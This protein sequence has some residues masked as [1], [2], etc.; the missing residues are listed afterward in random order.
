MSALSNYLESKIANW[1]DGT[2]AG[3]APTIIYVELRNGNPTDT[4]TGATATTGVNRAAVTLA[5]A[6][7]GATSNSAIIEFGTASASGT[8]DYFG[9]WDASTAGNLLVYGA[10]T[11]SKSIS[12]GD[13]VTI[14]ASALTVT[15]TGEFSTYTKNLWLNWM[16][17]TAISTLTAIYQGLYN[18]DPQSAGTEVTTTIRV[19]GRVV[20]PLGTATDGIISSNADVD[21]GTAAGGATVS[22]LSVHDAASGGNL[23]AADAITSRTV[24]TGDPV[25]IPSGDNTFTIA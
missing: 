20:I 11:A 16:R 2:A 25:L 17:G 18:G 13:A 6:S 14:A 23:L 1:L 8:A 24:S 4:G 10:L 12:N 19:A 7:G 3:T 22:Y 21:F 9:I 5:A 15:L